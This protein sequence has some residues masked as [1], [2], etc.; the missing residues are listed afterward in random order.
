MKV[1]EGP[2]K[3]VKQCTCKECSAKLEI[4]E[5]DLRV[6]NTAV[7]YAGETWEPAIVV[8][9]PVCKTDVYVTKKVPY[10]IQNRLYDKVRR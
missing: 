2:D 9:C 4:E 5:S 3:W 7:G 8:T 1:L 10:G 6:V